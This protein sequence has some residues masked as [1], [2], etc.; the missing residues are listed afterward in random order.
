MQDKKHLSHLKN[1]RSKSPLFYKNKFN[2]IYLLLTSIT[3][4]LLYHFDTAYS[5]HRKSCAEYSKYLVTKTLSVKTYMGVSVYVHISCA[6]IHA[7]V[8][9]DYVFYKINTT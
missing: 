1:D 4:I 3:F 5:V 9:I 2:C 7:I 8:L 6:I